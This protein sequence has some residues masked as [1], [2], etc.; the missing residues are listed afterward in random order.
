MF[1]I[2]TN[3]AWFFGA[4]LLVLIMPP[5]GIFLLILEVIRTKQIIKSLGPDVKLEMIKQ[6][7][8]SSDIK[9]LSSHQ[10]IKKLNG[11]N[12]STEDYISITKSNGKKEPVWHLFSLVFHIM[13][14]LPIVY[15]TL[16][17]KRSY[18]AP[19]FAG[20]EW[21]LLGAVF[22]IL[23][24]ISVTIAIIRKEP[25][26]YIVVTNIT[27]LFICMTTLITIGIIK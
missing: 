23:S 25:F 18:N 22:Y 9:Y 14:I 24:I 3:K 7:Y 4:L 6:I 15:L 11:G 27:L 19:M 2:I 26:S 10:Q 21:L 16:F 20:V 1:W 12:I 8:E 5:I 17:Y 13:G